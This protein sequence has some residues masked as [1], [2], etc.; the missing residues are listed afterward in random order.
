[1][2]FTKIRGNVQVQDLSLTNSQIALPDAANPKGIL[3]TKIEDGAL[4]VKSDGSVPF[5]APVSGVEP[6]QAS[7]LATKAYVDATAEGLDV[8]LSVRAVAT[9]NVALSGTQTIDGVSLV[10]GD[11]VLLTGQSNPVEN[12]IYVVAAGGWTRAADATTNADVTPG[13]FTFVEEGTYGAGTG[14]VLTSVGPTTLGQ[15][16]LPFAQ[17]SSAGVVQAGDGLAKNGNSLSVVSANGGIAVTPAGITLTL[18]GSTLAVGPNGLKLADLAEGQ[19]LVGSATGVATARTLSG[20]VTVNAA[21]VVTLTDGAVSGDKIADGSLELKKLDT[22]GAVA[23][24]VAVIGQD[25]VAK[26]V[27][28]SGDATLSETGA[29]ELGTGVVGTAELADKSVTLSKL[30][31]IPAGQLILGSTAGNKTV[32]LSGD[33]TIDEN[34]V[35][36]INPDTVIRVTD[37]VTRETPAG[38]LNGV[39][40]TFTLANDVKLGTESVFV[41]GLL[42]DAGASNDY[43]INGSTITM[44]YA[45]TAEDK[46]RVSYIADKA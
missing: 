24:S 34:G 46:I 12:G 2:A 21:G 4:L 8:K 33:V 5:T 41:N 45:L 6:T 26:F 28:V 13:L 40:D 23:G 7:H 22:D 14:W 30:A 38:A 18:D 3:L 9:D 37:F 35:V 20:D 19:I 43:T 36:T 42:Q 15:T 11:R 29:F 31:D 32:T 17:F 16:P 10:V 25:G 39:N 27:P 44:Q 1:M